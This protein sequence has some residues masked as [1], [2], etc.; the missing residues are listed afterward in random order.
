M[1][2]CEQIVEEICSRYAGLCELWFDG[3]V[4]TP[5]EG[6]PV[7]LPIV[8]RYQPDMVYY[9]GPD[10]AHHRWP[11][12][13]TG[14]TGDPCWSTV[15]SIESLY[16]NHSGKFVELRQGD[17]DGAAWCPAM[18]DAPIREHDW[19]WVP[20]TEQKLQP[21]DRLVSMYYNSVGRNANLMTGAVP[22]TDGLIDD[23]DLL[24][25]KEFGNEIKRRFGLPY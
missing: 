7:L 3:G 19:L 21:L 2:E 14:T 22:N 12:T 17:P 15:G 6:G 18:A 5:E 24:R 4:I 8:D 20:H 16:K 9:H 23:C 13:E 1:R 25:Y 10:R 11:G